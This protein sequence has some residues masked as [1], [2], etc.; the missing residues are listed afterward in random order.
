MKA[1]KRTVAALAVFASC[2]FAEGQ[3]AVEK[4]QPR[5]TDQVIPEKIKPA[6]PSP[7][8]PTDTSPLTEKSDGV[9]K[10][11][12]GIDPGIQISPPASPDSG[13]VDPK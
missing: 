12:P 5:E 9:L 6:T 11:Q 8:S 2:S 3:V 13:L 1:S 10:P 4:I 7:V